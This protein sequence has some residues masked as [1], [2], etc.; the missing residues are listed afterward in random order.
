MLG[1]WRRVVNLVGPEDWRD[2]LE[3]LVVDSFHLASFLDGLPL[4]PDA[5]CLDLGAG[6]GLPGLPL[7]MIRKDGRHVLVEA[8]EKRAMF[9]RAFLAANPLPGTV[10]YHGRAQDR[11]REAEKEGGA[12]FILSRAF[13]PWEKVLELAGPH[14]RSR[15]F[16]V[17]LSSAPLP[18]KF[19][20]T[21]CGTLPRTPPP[22][23][24]GGGRET[25]RTAGGW[26]ASAEAGYTVD[27]STR[28]FWAL[29]KI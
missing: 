14:M 4:P 12:A 10:V 26:T 18:S 24:A 22:E 21:L 19:P 15:G 20:P 29:Q 7:R 16:C 3:K 1:K 2:I 9:L 28:Y 6:A 8:R 13:M 11:L 23:P 5:A 27:N 17:F 25:G